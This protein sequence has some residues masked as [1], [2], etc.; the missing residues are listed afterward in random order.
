MLPTSSAA[1]GCG[2]IRFSRL[3][4]V[5]TLEEVP[6]SHQFIDVRDILVTV[7]LHD[8]RVPVSRH[9]QFSIR[10]LVDVGDLAQECTKIPPFEIA[11]RRVLEDGLIGAQVSSSEFWLH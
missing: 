3:S 11:R 5:R 6:D 1:L 4:R 9:F 10:F 2:I 8:E 7:G